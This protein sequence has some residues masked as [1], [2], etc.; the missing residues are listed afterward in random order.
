MLSTV[1]WASAAGGSWSTAADWSTHALPQSGDDVVID[2]P[3]NIQ[4]T[5]SGSVS[6]NSVTVTGDTLVLQPGATLTT[7]GAVSNAGTITVDASAQLA[8]GGA[9]TESAGAT[10]SMPG[11][12][13]SI[14]PTSNQFADT[15]FESPVVTANGTTS[16]SSWS[17]WGS[18]YLSKQYAYTGSQSLQTSGAN[19]GVLQSFSVTPGASYTLSAYAMTP[20]AN[21]LTGSEEGSLQLIFLTSSG[22]QISPYSPPNSVQELSSASNPGGPIAGSVGSQGWNHFSTTAVAPSNAATVDA[23]LGVGAYNGSGA[24]GGSV[25]WDAPKFGPAVPGPSKVTAASISNSGAITVGPSNTLTSNGTFT[26]TSTGTLDVQLGG[27]PSS[28]AFGYVSSAGAVSL[29]GTLKSDIV[30]GYVP[31][32][33]DVFTVMEY[34]SETGSFAS[35]TLAG[36]TAAQ[37]QGAVT[38]TND[39]LAAEP[40]ATLTAT[41]N[42]ASNLRAVN[43]NLLGT[44]LAWWYGDATTSQTQQM[45]EQAGLNIYRFPG[46]SSSDDYHFNSS[47]VSGD[48]YAET[49]PQFAK[50]IQTVGGTGLITLD[51]GSGSPQEAAAEMAYLVGSPSD[52]TTVGTGIEWNDSTGAWQNVNW[53]TVGYWAGL[54][55]ASPLATNDGLNFLRIDHPAPFSNIKY[56]EIG[57]EEY[58]NWEV[59]HHGTAGPGSVSTGAQHDPA[60]YVTFA[61]AFSTYAA[62]ILAT[63]GLPSISIGIDSEDPTGA[64]D[65]DWTKN[66]LTSGLAIGFVPN[67]IS[68][69]SYMQAPGD[70]NDSFLLN[71]TVSDSSSLFDWSVR[72]ADY[73]TLL[74]QTVPSQASSVTVMATEFN[75]VYSDPGKQSTSLVN[76]LFV[77]DSIGSLLDSGYSGGIVWDLRNG[78]DTTQNN[79]EALYGW[80]DGGDYGILGDPNVNSAPTSAPYVPYPSYF[81][82]QLASKI[83]DAGGDVESVSTNYHDFDAYAVME[84]DGHLDLL[85]IN[86][87]PAASLTEQF[88]LTGFQPSGAAEFWQYGQAQDTAQSQSGTGASALSNFSATLGLTGNNFSYSF[89]AYSMTVI[90]LTPA[91]AAPTV[92]SV[93]PQDNAGNGVAAGSA[94]KGQR[95][96]ETQIA[97]AFSEPVDLA[98]G[99]FTIGLANQYGSGTNNGS[100]DTLLNGVLGTPTN[101]S[102]DGMTWIIPILSNGTNS[103]A[104]NG[105]HGGISGASLDNGVY[106]LNVIAADV[107]TS[108]GGVAM[109]SNY[110]SAYWHRLYGDIDNARR[111]F[112]TQYSA[113]LAAYSSTY[114]SNGATIYNEDLDFD[115]DGRVFNT[116]YAAFLADFGSGK[117]YTEPES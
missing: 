65:N 101:P 7:A 2:Q 36:S 62:E 72:Y 10:L 91:V 52:T 75:S 39:V 35:Y 59:D 92:V 58:G 63:A 60:T 32:T 55:A 85:V 82:E 117:T 57:N 73:Q 37:F 20:P 25:Y 27:S 17:T 115:G 79:S 19:S 103:Y 71:D 5:V 56:W 47:T 53:G 16:P 28:G 23:V 99:A 109:T 43:T 107:T 110:S 112:N 114:E 31:A 106:R 26:Q 64:A 116:D 95:S 77:A 102:G 100:A 51:Y 44:N 38:F 93:T 111:V 108:T 113:F 69:H 1:T 14:D 29:A 81:G 11:G 13:S 61:K 4:I 96:M 18:S 33:T 83:I 97:V 88:N 76:G 42:A 84:A 30:Y 90:D 8:V 98:S 87:N 67:F 46:G 80:R 22:A 78:Y 12:G 94:A 34:P 86:T 24:G 50:F 66:V 9:Y 68:D 6:V 3:G 89:P 48:A 40:T 54:R 45:V 49:I 15:D 74:Q 21:P 70:E 41:V 104:L 105:T